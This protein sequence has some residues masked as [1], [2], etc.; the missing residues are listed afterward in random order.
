MGMRDGQLLQLALVPPPPP[1]APG[2][3]A[4]I[5]AAAQRIHAALS[6]HAPPDHARGEA[7]PGRPEQ[8]QAPVAQPVPPVSTA[9]GWRSMP[10]D[11]GNAATQASTSSRVHSGGACSSSA[12]GCLHLQDC[13]P[14]CGHPLVL[15]ALPEGAG[16]SAIAV[17][18]AA[19]LLPRPPGGCRLAPAKLALPGALHVAA[20]WQPPSDGGPRRARMRGGH[21]FVWRGCDSACLCDGQG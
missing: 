15:A 6:L 10:G 9:G 3:E 17:G 20:L 19:W 18:Q 21:L 13:W 16:A 1:P 2:T 14:L 5:S 12:C 7:S 8:G 11:D 4:A